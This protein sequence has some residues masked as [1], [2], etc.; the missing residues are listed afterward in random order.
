MDFGDIKNAFRPLHDR[1]HLSRWRGAAVLLVAGLLKR[2]EMTPGLKRVGIEPH[3][4]GNQD[5]V[6][7][8]KNR[9]VEIDHEV[10]LPENFPRAQLDDSYGTAEEVLPVDCG[11]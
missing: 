3:R 4:R 1:M 9:P 8:D 7:N 6:V 10:L 5:F 11:S 2:P